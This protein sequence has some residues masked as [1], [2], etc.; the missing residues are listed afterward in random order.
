[1]KRN[2]SSRVRIP[3][4]KVRLTKEEKLAIPHWEEQV[5]LFQRTCDLRSN[6]KRE[7]FRTCLHEGSHAV[8]YGRFGW[9]VE[10]LG[11]YVEYREGKLEFVVGAVSPLPLKEYNPLPW[12]H[13]AVSIAG[14]KW[15][16]HFT[17]LPNEDF[18]IQND[19]ASLRS[20]LGESADAN[21]A[22]SQAES[23]LEDQLSQPGFVD[24]LREMVRAY[25]FIVYN[26]NEA[27]EWGWK[28]YQPGLSGER[29]RVT[30]PVAGYYGTLIENEGE[31]KLV[32]MGEVYRP[33]E[34]LYGVRSEVM[35]A[36]PKRPG[37]DR[38]VRRW[39]Q[40]ASATEVKW[41]LN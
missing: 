26:S 17:G 12:E 32:V 6:D 18:T 20:K 37:A 4:V 36:E 23:N 34:K 38:A 33:G 14:F 28:E 21:E 9:N 27:T 11:P 41:K 29:Y 25:E 30:V 15:V 24:E 22:V 19:L 13:A 39:N 3:K 10:F 2:E 8:Q 35:T 5:A 7:R 40:A 1:M 16:E 31:L